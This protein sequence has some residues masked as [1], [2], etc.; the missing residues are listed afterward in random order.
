MV[1]KPIYF[2]VIAPHKHQFS[3]ELSPSRRMMPKISRVKL[4]VALRLQI[5]DAERPPLSINPPILNERSLLRTRSEPIFQSGMPNFDDLPNRNGVEKR[6]AIADIHQV[7][8]PFHLDKERLMGT[9][10]CDGTRDRKAP[11]SELL[12]QPPERSRDLIAQSSAP[13]HFPLFQ[14]PFRIRS[15]RTAPEIAKAQDRR[16]VFERNTFEML[17]RDLTQRGDARGLRRYP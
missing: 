14:K 9:R 5:V 2:G 6:S 17:L 10:E 15:R 12:E 13:L 1:P 11:V 7:A 16:H 8:P 4:R 3:Q